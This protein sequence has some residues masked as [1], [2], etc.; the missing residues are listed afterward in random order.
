MDSAE[1]G[2][3][4][5][6]HQT[7]YNDADVDFMASPSDDD[8]YNACLSAN[9]GVDNCA[10]KA[11]TIE[12][13]FLRD[14]WPIQQQVFGGSYDPELSRFSH[15]RGFDV[16][17]GCNVI[18]GTVSEKACCGSYPTRYPFRTLGGDR[19]CCGD[20]TFPTSTFEC[21]NDNT[22]SLSCP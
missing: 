12:V 8:V 7:D 15:D 21:C 1:S 14:W 2:E 9:G 18:P 4:C 6:G 13:S 16:T 20:R 10:V 19:G 22:V 5:I 17:T 11:C 3:N